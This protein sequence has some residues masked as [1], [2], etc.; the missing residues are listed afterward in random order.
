[1]HHPLILA[2]VVALFFPPFALA[3]EPAGAVKEKGKDP[4]AGRT[5]KH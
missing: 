3:K 5:K 1:M 4:K 2:A